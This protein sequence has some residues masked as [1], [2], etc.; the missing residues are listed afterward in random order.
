MSR[1]RRRNE[2]GR[3][4]NTLI[5]NQ[6]L[7]ASIDVFNLRQLELPLTLIDDRR[8]YHPDPARLPKMI[9]GAPVSF[10]V[11]KKPTTYQ[12]SLKKN[13]QSYV[14]NLISFAENKN[15]LICIRRKK[16]KEVLFAK[17]K[18]GMRGQKRPRFNSYSSIHCVR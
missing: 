6:R 4:D 18:T 3:R 2:K 16:R 8:T 11:R 12:K 5:A 15:V 10:K 14:P 7:P 13:W 1:R 9:T 17:K